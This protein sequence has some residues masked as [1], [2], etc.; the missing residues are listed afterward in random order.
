MKANDQRWSDRKP[1][2]KRFLSIVATALVVTLALAGCQRTP[3]LANEESLGAADALWTAITAKDVKL[4]D[5]SE[6]TLKQLHDQSKLTNEAFE[7]LE[8]MIATARAGDWDGAR[9]DLKA[10]V[11]GQ[12]PP[13]KQ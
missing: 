1:T 10:F 13:E 6:Q 3:Q 7:S 12:R 4:V 5:N 8:G 11:R 9:G 2:S